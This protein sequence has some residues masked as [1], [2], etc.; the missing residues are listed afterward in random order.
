MRYCANHPCRTYFDNH[1]ANRKYCRPCSIRKQYRARK[2]SRERAILLLSEYGLAK[3]TQEFPFDLFSGEENVLEFKRGVGLV[4]EDEADKARR[5]N[6][7]P[8]PQPKL[9][10]K[11]NSSISISKMEARL[12]ELLVRFSYGF[13][14]LYVPFL[15]KK[16]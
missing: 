1:N 14:W 10:S 12:L 7:I 16:L 9:L 3:G 5:A 11:K 4:D 2:I 6:F 13:R 8:P 15:E